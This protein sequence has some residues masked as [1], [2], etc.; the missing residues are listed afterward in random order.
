MVLVVV[1]MIV[2][3]ILAVAA[4]RAQLCIVAAQCIAQHSAMV[5]ACWL[6]GHQQVC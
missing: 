6:S 1:L 5:Q 3:V 4:A 2:A